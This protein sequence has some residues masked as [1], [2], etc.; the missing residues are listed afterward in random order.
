MNTLVIVLVA[1]VCLAAGYLFYGRWLD[2]YKRQM[3]SSAQSAEMKKEITARS[4][5]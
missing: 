4:W 2:V 1:G 5:W 3:M